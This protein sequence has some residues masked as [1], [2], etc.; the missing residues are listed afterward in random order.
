MKNNIKLCYLYICDEE[1]KYEISLDNELSFKY[2]TNTINISKKENYIKHF[3]G[4]NINNFNLFIGKNASGKTTYL[5]KII[6]SIDYLESNM[7]KI[8]NINDKYVVFYDKKFKLNEELVVQNFNDIDCKDVEL[9]SYEL[10][11]YLLLN[12]EI[13]EKYINNDSG[14]SSIYF[15]NQF[16]MSSYLISRNMS[17]KVYFPYN[18]GIKYLLTFPSDMLENNFKDKNFYM[19]E[20]KL[21]NYY[22][23]YL[24]Y[25]ICNFISKNKLIIDL[26]KIDSIKK[27]AITSNQNFKNT[28]N[29]RKIIT[30]LGNENDNKKI[31]LDFIEKC[32][33]INDKYKVF[34]VAMISTLY[35]GIEYLVYEGQHNTDCKLELKK[36]LFNW[37]RQVQDKLS[38]NNIT[39]LKELLNIYNTFLKKHKNEIYTP[40][41]ENISINCIQK[42]IELID[43][44]DEQKNSYE[45]KNE[46]NSIKFI[47]DISNLEFL[48]KFINYI[49][50]AFENSISFFTYKF[51][52]IKNKMV[53][54]SSGEEEIL[55]MFSKIYKALQDMTTTYAKENSYEDVNKKLDTVLIFLDEPDIYLHP[56]WKR[57]FLSSF[58]EYIKEI[59]K[60]VNVQLI[61][62]TNSPILAGDVPRQDI[63]KFENKQIEEYNNSL[64]DTFAKNLLSLFKETFGMQSLLGNFS[65]KKINKVIEQIQKNNLDEQ[66][67]NNIQKLINIIGEPVIKRKIQEIYDEKYNSG[68]TKEEINIINNAKSK[69]YTI[70]QISDLTGISKDKIQIV[71]GIQ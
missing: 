17:E 24:Y 40:S 25:N 23:N 60:E 41:I 38:E 37:M 32:K 28:S 43:F 6:D 29:V 9:E 1:D 48:N 31:Y 64:E 53:S 3:Y 7:I 57:I 35:N 69:G 4:E 58:F 67:R 10:E 20:S 21:V 66:E 36:T 44:L 13:Y 65:T 34:L 49:C 56:E 27:I 2:C 12:P 61:I 50:D 71:I 22:E 55:S 52:D 11:D 26:F 62:T 14:Y 45:F 15:S 5:N 30:D 39:L 68:L 18:I 59:F 42:T 63:I 8:I 16:S 46:N 54:L 19:S 47:V 51:Y 70:D 33:K